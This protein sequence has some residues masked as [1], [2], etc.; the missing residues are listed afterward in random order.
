MVHARSLTGIPF[1]GKPDTKQKP[2]S[3]IGK[4]GS[5]DDPGQML[6]GWTGWAERGLDD[7][8][9]KGVITPEAAVGEYVTSQAAL[10]QLLSERRRAV[11]IV[12]AEGTNYEGEAGFWSGTG[13]LVSPNL[14]LTN[15]HVLN[16]TVVAKNA[17]VEF[18]YEISPEGLLAGDGRAPQATQTFAIDPARLFITS[19]TEGGLDYTFIW[20]EDAAAA[21]YGIIPMERAFFTVSKEE[22]AFVIHH[23]DGQPKQVS[24]DDTDILSIDANVIHYSSD[25]MKGSSGAPVFDRRG[26]LIALH[27]ASRAEKVK[28]PDG[29]TSD[30]V[31]EGIKIAAIALDLEMRMRKGGTDASYAETILKSIKGSDT[32]SGF[33]GGLGRRI[34]A[35]EPGPEAVVD[36]YRGSD[37]DVDVGFWNIEWLANRYDQPVKLDGAAKVISDLS[38]D[39]WGLAEIS[40]PA[41]DALVK[42][43]QRIY[44]DRYDSAF[45]EPDAAQSKQSTAMIWKSSSLTGKRVEWPE[46][47]EK[48]FRQRSDDPNLEVE[49]VHGKIFDRYPGLFRFK[50]VKPLP[51]YEFFVVPLHL[52]AMDEGSLRRRLATRILARAVEQI[53]L[54]TKLDVILGGDMNAPLASGDFTAIADASFDVLGAQDEADGAFTYVKSPKSAIDN[55]FLSPSM[56]QTVGTADFFI[57]AKDRTMPNYLEIT[58]HRPVAVRL[59]LSKR[60]VRSRQ[61]QKDLDAMIDAMIGQSPKPAVKKRKTAKA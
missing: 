38:L 48:L 13:F 34:D 25:T 36:T 33:F 59:C 60:G 19:P 42:N 58:D 7:A 27:H 17:K 37:Q 6:K 24:L 32:M 39:V 5:V 31:N 12:S 56:R 23:P 21:A 1:V 57:V 14:L 10:L 4:L 49:A 54:D 26:R 35:S 51:A 11:A 28:L 45:S 61:D 18:N 15:H 55:I 30:V 50:T 43:I 8:V 2:F 20:I 29:G 46:A 16:S 3:E 44:G 9:E 47:I 41:V 52:K 22:S 40:P 53:S